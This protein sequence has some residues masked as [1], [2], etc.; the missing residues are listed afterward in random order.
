[1][2]CKLKKAIGAVKDQTSI[3]LAKVA[4]NNSSNLEVMVLKATTHDGDEHYVHEILRLLSSSKEQVA[5]CTRAIGKRIGRTRNWIVVV[6]S[7]MP[8]L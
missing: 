4:G 1:M 3:S 8:V 6:K 5:A 2:A 7:L